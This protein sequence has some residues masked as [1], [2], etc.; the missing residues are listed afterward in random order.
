V[1]NQGSKATTDSGD[2]GGIVWSGAAWMFAPVRPETQCPSRARADEVKHGV[3]F[4]AERARA[5]GSE[6]A[7]VLL[8]NYNHVARTLG[9][10]VLP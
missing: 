2:S 8:E 5:A 1:I 3:L 7:R 4:A 10:K 6:R 9:I